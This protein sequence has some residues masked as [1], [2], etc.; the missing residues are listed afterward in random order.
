[1]TRMTMPRFH[2]SLHRAGQPLPFAT[3]VDFADFDE[4]RDEADKSAREILMSAVAT[5]DEDVP[6]RV[7]VSDDAGRELVTVRLIDVIPRSLRNSG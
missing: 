2:I 1:M 5:G 4:A 3:G 7:V 6:D